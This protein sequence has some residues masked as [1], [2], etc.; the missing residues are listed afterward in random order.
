MGSFLTLRNELAQEIHML[1][2]NR[3]L[4]KRRLGREQQEK[5]TQENCS[6]LW[7]AVSGFMV[8]GLVSSLSLASHL[9]WP[10]V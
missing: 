8:M 2:K 9:A 10:V 5:G 1:T 7:V 4:E 3:L 6:A